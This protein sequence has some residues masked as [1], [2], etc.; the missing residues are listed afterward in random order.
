MPRH[1]TLCLELVVRRNQLLKKGSESALGF[2]SRRGHDAVS[3]DSKGLWH[4]AHLACSCLT[5]STHLQ[6]PIQGMLF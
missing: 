1:P 5:H 4:R 6:D 2:G 3:M